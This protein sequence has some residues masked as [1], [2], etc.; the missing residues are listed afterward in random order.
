MIP[1]VFLCSMRRGGSRKEKNNPNDLEVEPKGLEFW[2]SVQFNRDL[3]HKQNRPRF[4]LRS[5]NGH[6]NSINYSVDPCLLAFSHLGAFGQ[7]RSV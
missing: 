6:I 3:L 2:N 7:K 5:D 4:T 1:S